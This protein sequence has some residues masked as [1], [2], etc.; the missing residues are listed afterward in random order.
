MATAY[1]LI[2]R[3]GWVQRIY[4]TKELGFCVK[5]GIQRAYP[6]DK[7]RKMFHRLK[8]AA[9]CKNIVAWNDSA[10][11]TKQNVLAALKKAKV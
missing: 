11:Q 4:G 7:W 5:G 6:F 3:Y 10:L 1:G 9:G 2:R 8:R